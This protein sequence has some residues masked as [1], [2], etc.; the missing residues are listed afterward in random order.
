GV[1]SAL[2]RGLSGG[3]SDFGPAKADILSSPSSLSSLL[4][5]I[6]SVWVTP[7][8]VWVSV[9][10]PLGFRWVSVG[11]LGLPPLPPFSQFFTSFALVS[12][13]PCATIADPFTSMNP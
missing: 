6:G 9:G 7:K 2:F 11:F 12:A 8:P 1:A 10:F 13:H 5:S 3:G 4:F